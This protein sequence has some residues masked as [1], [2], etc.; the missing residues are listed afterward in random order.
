MQTRE[1]HTHRQPDLGQAAYTTD[2]VIIHTRVH[3]TDE[4]YLINPNNHGGR[5]APRKRDEHGNEICKR[6][7]IVN[8][9]TSY[10]Y[11][12]KR[13]KHNIL[14]C[15]KCMSMR[16]AELKKQRESLEHLITQIC[17]IYGAEP[18]SV[19]HARYAP[20]LKTLLMHYLAKHGS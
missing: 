8:E 14:I 15:A 6:G 7:H 18:G 13:L 1:I 9:Q 20:K 4:P 17:R 16:R 3:T 19:W 10:L 2:T 12:D 5:G 11:Y